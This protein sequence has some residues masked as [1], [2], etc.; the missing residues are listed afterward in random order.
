MKHNSKFLHGRI[1][2]QILFELWDLVSCYW[3]IKNL[4]DVLPRE[5]KEWLRRELIDNLIPDG[6]RIKGQGTF[7]N[8]AQVKLTSWR[9]SPLP[10]HSRK[11]ALATRQKDE[12]VEKLCELVRATPGDF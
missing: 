9:S 10:L 12:I 11:R 6:K 5:Q 4:T 8:R 2:D 3:H 1:I 7:L